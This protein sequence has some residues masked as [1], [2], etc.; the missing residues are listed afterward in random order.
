MRSRSPSPRSVMDKAKEAMI[1]AQTRGRGKRSRRSA[2]T[3]AG[4]QEK[5]PGLSAG[6]VAE[7]SAGPPQ[8][9][10]PIHGPRRPPSTR[11]GPEHL[12]KVMSL[13]SDANLDRL[14]E[15]AAL[16][17]ERLRTARPLRLPW[18]D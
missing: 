2:R 9:V 11:F 10:A 4:K 8:P 1:D 5:R 14:C 18:P 6:R 17:I 12:R 16:E 3:P 13:S 7:S 15:D